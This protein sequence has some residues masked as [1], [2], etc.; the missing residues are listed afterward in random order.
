MIKIKLNYIIKKEIIVIILESTEE[1][2]TVFELQNTNQLNCSLRYKIPKNI[3]AVFHN[4]STFDHH[5]IIK[6]LAKE[7]E[8]QFECIRENTKQCI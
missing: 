7:V 3:S 4:G 5:V 6:E 8:V 1:L 2:L